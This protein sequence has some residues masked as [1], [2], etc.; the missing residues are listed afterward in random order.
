MMVERPADGNAITLFEIL[1]DDARRFV[2]ASDAN[3]PGFL[4]TCTEGKVEIGDRKTFRIVKDFGVI[5]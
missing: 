3:P 1:L 4:F 5:A 2:K